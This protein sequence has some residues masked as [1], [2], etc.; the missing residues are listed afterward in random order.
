MKN[1]R[2]AL[3]LNCM[4]IQGRHGAFRKT[5]IESGEPSLLLLCEAAQTEE[6]CRMSPTSPLPPEEALSPDG[7]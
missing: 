7:Q 1:D 6:W 3:P 4:H 5:I 2:L